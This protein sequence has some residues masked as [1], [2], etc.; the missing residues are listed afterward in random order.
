MYF[1]FYDNN[2]KAYCP[3]NL[4]EFYGDE[5]IYEND[6]LDRIKYDYLYLCKNIVYNKKA[7]CIYYS[8]FRRTIYLIKNYKDYCYYYMKKKKN[9]RYFILAD[10]FILDEN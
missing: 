4:I 3:N 5:Y 8:S 6:F 1:N 9:S 7:N 10:V 2:G